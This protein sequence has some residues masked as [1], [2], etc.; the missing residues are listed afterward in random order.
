MKFSGKVILTGVMA[1]LVL[2]GMM[3]F[4]APMMGVHMDIAASMAG[5]MGA[6]WVVG[7]AAHLMLGIL[8][9]PQVYFHLFSMRLPGQP[10]VRGLLFSGLL[11]MMLEVALMPMLGEGFFGMK[12]PGMMGAVAALMAHAVYGSIL[13]WGTGK[14]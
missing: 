5:M 8:V 10:V 11:W 12:G 1:T 14:A 9:F 6:P 13:G 4:V 2:T 7:F 3:K